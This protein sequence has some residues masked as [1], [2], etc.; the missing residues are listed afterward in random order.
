MLKTNLNFK[1]STSKTVATHLPCPMCTSSDAYTLF[2]DGHG[3]CF[4]CGERHSPNSKK[5]A[6]LP[7]ETG[8]ELLPYN[9]PYTFQY[10]DWRGIISG[11]MAKFRISTKVDK[12][13]TPVSVGFQYPSG[14]VKTRYLHAKEFSWDGKNDKGGGWLFGMDIFPPAS[15]PSVTIVEGEVDA[16]SVYQM[17]GNGHAVVGLRGASSAR[18]DCGEAFEYLNS[19]DKIVLCLD[20]DKAGRQ[21]ARQIANLFDFNKVVEVKLDEKLKDGNGYLEANRQKEFVNAWNTAKRYLPEGV[22]SDFTEF[23]TIIDEDADKP[24]IPYPFEILN[25]KE[26][27]L[28]TG[29]FV[30]VKAPEGVGKTEFLRAIEYHRLSTTDHRVGAI[31]LEESKAR[32]LKGIATYALR[33]PA[34]LPDFG[35]TRE[36]IKEA[37]RKATTDADGGTRLHLYSHFGSDDPDVLLDTVRFLGGVCGCKLVTFDHIT[38]AVTGLEGD[39]ERRKLDYLSTQ[40]A[41]IAHDLDFTILCVSH[42]NDEGQTRGSRNI[43]KVAHT[44]IAISRNLM[45]EDELTRNI[46]WVNIEKARFTG[47]TGPAGQLQ[48]DPNTYILSDFHAGE[49]PIE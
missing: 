19:F 18:K 21:A 41:K 8:R 39:D 25:A 30:L 32:Q 33:R 35:V 10:L 43:G 34:H 9:G 15:S 12:D 13:G 36:D 44:V 48:F 49:L 3:Y 22:V 26:I 28:R 5:E 29:E 6:K 27:G 31:H 2:E 37:Y 38:M 11:V 40:L 17:L 1:P 14:G 45:A 20:A 7:K 16:P 23:D 24:S 4:S 46:M 47:K 42:V